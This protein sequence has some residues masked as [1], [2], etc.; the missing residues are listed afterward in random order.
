VTGKTLELTLIHAPAGLKAARPATRR[1]RKREQFNGA[2]LRKIAGAALRY[3][4]G[5]S[6]KNFAF[7][8]RESDVPVKMPR[9]LSEGAVAA[10]SNDKYK[11]DKKTIRT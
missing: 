5:R 6:A 3:L 9:P 4:K 7:L 1:S 2:T 8:I 11:T 10:I